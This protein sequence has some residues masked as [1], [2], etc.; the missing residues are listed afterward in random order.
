M[1]SDLTNET[2]NAGIDNVGNPTS[3][4]IN[5]TETSN[6]ETSNVGNPTSLRKQEQKEE[7]TSNTEETAFGFFNKFTGKS[8]LTKWTLTNYKLQTTNYKLQTT[9]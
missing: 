9:Y 1:S 7:K 5:T 8:L 3:S 2:S 4:I 6:T